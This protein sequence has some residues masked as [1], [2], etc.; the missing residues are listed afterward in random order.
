M[1]VQDDEIVLDISSC[2]IT[3]L[4]DHPELVASV[5]ELGIARKMRENVETCSAASNVY[6]LCLLVLCAV[7]RSPSV[8][9][10]TVVLCS[11]PVA[12]GSGAHAHH[13]HHHCAVG[14]PALAAQAASSSSSSSAS[15]HVFGGAVAAGGNTYSFGMAAPTGGFHFGADP[16]PA[17][18]SAASS[19]A[20]G[21]VLW[22]IVKHLG[23]TENAL[24]KSD[25]CRSLVGVMDMGALYAEVCVQAG[26]DTVLERLLAQDSFDLK[27]D[28][29]TNIRRCCVCYVPLPPPRC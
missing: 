7:L 22:H 19:S 23:R 1:F 27:I 24:T 2:L 26:L 17:Q 20:S 3:L 29:G 18:A 11:G 13:T 4:Q 8:L 16:S 5:L 15:M 14:A 6:E 28:A 10:R 21:S 12:A 25:I 9:H